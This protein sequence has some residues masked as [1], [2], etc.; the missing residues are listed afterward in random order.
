M[1]LKAHLWPQPHQIVSDS[2]V[3]SGFTLCVP[4]SSINVYKCPLF[5]LEAQS[6]N[7]QSL[8][9]G[10]VHQLNIILQGEE[11]DSG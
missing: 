5:F 1:V 7:A 9:V 10:K 8:R 2:S 4:F 11:I 3:L 6:R